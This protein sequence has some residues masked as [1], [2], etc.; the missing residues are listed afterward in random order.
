MTAS[1]MIDYDNIIEGK[2]KDRKIRNVIKPSHIPKN[3][4][5][6]LVVEVPSKEYQKISSLP[7]GEKRVDYLFSNNFENS[8][9]FHSFCF[10]NKKKGLCL[11]EFESKSNLEKLLFSLRQTMADAL[12]IWIK[13]NIQ[14][15]NFDS[16]VKQLCQVGF[17]HPYIKNNQLIMYKKNKESD[18]Q[19]S[20]FVLN[21]IQNLLQNEADSCH[22]Y[23]RLTNDAI[24]YLSTTS[25]KGFTKNKD[26]SSSQKEMTGELILKNAVNEK[27]KIIY[28]IDVNHGSVVSGEEELV[29]VNRTRYNFHSHPREAY[30]RHSVH[31]AW[32]SIVDFI[33]FFSLGSDTIFHCVATIEGVYI[34]SFGKYWHTK[35]KEI[36]KSFI[37]KNYDFDHKE[38]MT[39]LQYVEKVNNI[40]Y[41]NYPIF[42]LWFFKWN[43]ASTPF[44]ID[45]SPIEGVCF[46]NQESFEFH[47]KNFS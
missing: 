9:L 25:E 3:Y 45:Y 5:L 43:E 39:P 26:G 14:N 40:K 34:M 31:K 29:D 30:V 4:T 38:N 11:I 10:Y 7:K 32:P 13:V 1:M 41:K 35:L 36:S 44:K 12:I 42:K 16:I 18:N 17:K 46:V 19:A 20:N 6:G 27:D 15:S 8:I 47:K 37:E 33:G 21:K 24:E 23:A 28:E 22:L 2:G